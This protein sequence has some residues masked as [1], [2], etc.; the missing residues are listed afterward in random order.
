M[1]IIDVKFSSSCYMDGKLIYFR[2]NGEDETVAV[3]ADDNI[4]RK[5]GIEPKEVLKAISKLTV[6]KMLN[7]TKKELIEQVGEESYNQKTEELKKHLATEIE[8]N[9]YKTTNHDV[10]INAVKAHFNL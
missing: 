10:L 8:I 4:C 9:S 7:V 3:I 1:K 6:E 5:M 2:S